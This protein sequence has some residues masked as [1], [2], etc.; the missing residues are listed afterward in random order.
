MGK[1]VCTTSML[2][3]DFYTLFIFIHLFL[4]IQL[5]LFSLFLQVHINLGAGESEV[6]S[7]R[8][9][10]LDDLKWHEVKITRTQADLSLTIDRKHS[11]R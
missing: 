3:T 6:A 1:Y 9:L 2:K 5:N 10:R 4:L 7:P 8:G 11:T